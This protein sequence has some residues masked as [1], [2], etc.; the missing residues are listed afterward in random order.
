MEKQT[1]DANQFVSDQLKS[2]SDTAHKFKE[3]LRNT[4][5]QIDSGYKAAMLMYK[6]TFYTGII[7]IIFS[8]IYAVI[9]KEQLIPIVFG[10]LGTVDIVF[11]FVTKPIKDLQKSRSS[12]A[13][14]QSAYFN[15]FVDVM[16]WN[17]FLKIEGEANRIDEKAMEFVSNK[18][19]ENTEKTLA[20]VKNYC[21][22]P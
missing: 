5:E 11:F 19:F 6:V 20:L 14:L 4:L 10:G 15:W 17:G 16:N 21:D 1:F 12:L 3:G 7:L 18:L 13:Q 22:K 9:T 8:L 2:T